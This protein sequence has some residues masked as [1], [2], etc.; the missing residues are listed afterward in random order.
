MSC[1]Y[2]DG[3]SPYE[4]KGEVG[5]NEV[6]K[7][8]NCHREIGFDS[9]EVRE[10]AHSLAGQSIVKISIIIHFYLFQVFDTPEVLKQKISLLAQWIKDSKYT[11]FHTGAGISTSAGIPDFR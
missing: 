5:M 11:V 3:L 1:N 2:A 8:I 10:D 4:Y 6:S 7:I 9:R